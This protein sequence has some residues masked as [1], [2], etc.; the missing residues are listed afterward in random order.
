MILI[1]QVNKATQEF[2][3]LSSGDFESPL[4]LTIP[5]GGK[6]KTAKL[7][8]RND[9][10]DKYYTGLVLRP[11]S[12]TGGEI[13][14]TTVK[15]KLLSGDREPSETRWSEVGFNGLDSM[16][17]G[18]CAILQSPS[19]GGAIDTRIPVLGSA[20]AADTKFYPFWVRIEAA[21]GTPLGEM[22]LGFSLTY[23]E[24]LVS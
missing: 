4:S 18:S 23:T 21:R 13:L 10:E 20:D 24:A 9:D 5:P 17:P 22:Q 3:E 14:G 8:L 1:Y 11:C 2:E 12:L 7:Y 6:Y 19:A 15:V 16:L